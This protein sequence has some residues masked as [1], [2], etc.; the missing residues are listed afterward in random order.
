[1]REIKI[2]VR[3]FENG[4]VYNRSGQIV[5]ESSTGKYES[6]GSKSGTFTIAAAPTIESLNGLT[7]LKYTS[8]TE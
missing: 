4:G 7:T 5:D 1:M 3:A 6:T 2:A 8:E